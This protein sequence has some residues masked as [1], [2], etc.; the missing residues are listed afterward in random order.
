MNSQ[1]YFAMPSPPHNAEDHLR[2]YITAQQ[3]ALGRITKQGEPITPL[4]E[5]SDLDPS[6]RKLV[7][8]LYDNTELAIGVSV[9]K[10]DFS[11]VGFLTFNQSSDELQNLM[12]D[13]YDTP[14]LK[15]LQIDV[16][17][18]IDHGIVEVVIHK[19]QRV[20]FLTAKGEGIVDDRD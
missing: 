15:Q 1:P 13:M 7:D 5:Y 20:V 11:D 10:Q 3:R 16:D 8:Y 19:Q 18:L 12:K 4:T 17:F 6:V 14:N 9:I 2:T